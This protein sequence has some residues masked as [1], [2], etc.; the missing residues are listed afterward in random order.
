[1][2]LTG[3]KTESVYRRYA[4]VDETILREGPKSSPLFT[5]PRKAIEV[6]SYLYLHHRIEQNRGRATV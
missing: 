1:M 5:R 2:N 6:P 3:H 4:I